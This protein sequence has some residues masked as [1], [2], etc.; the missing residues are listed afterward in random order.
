MPKNNCKIVIIG[1]GAVGKTSLLYVYAK[2]VFPTDYVPTVFDNYYTN[3][4]IDGLPIK[5]GLW[6]TAGQ[7]DFEQLRPLSYPDTDVFCLCFSI[8][9]RGSFE[10]IPTKWKKELK[11]HGPK[12]PVIL[13]GT[14]SD[15]LDDH[16]LLEHLKSKNRSHVTRE[17][18]LSMA[19][20]INARK[21]VSCSAKEKI[22]VEGV[23]KSAIRTA[24]FKSTDDKRVEEKSRCIIL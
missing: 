19:K 20:K 17:E 6:D 11:R 4:K 24:L 14:Q 1:D 22:N 5:V 16:D 7:E 18:G 3:V 15:L 21:Y 10:N 13:V 8:V 9:N 12:V 2:G 23:F